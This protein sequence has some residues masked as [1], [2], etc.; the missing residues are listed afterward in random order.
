MVEDGAGIG[1]EN[2]V[3]DVGV[4]FENI[5]MDRSVD[6]FIE[7]QQQPVE[8]VPT[9]FPEWNDMC[10]GDGGRTGLALGWHVVIGGATNMGK[11]M[12]ALNLGARAI[13]EGYDVGMVS[14]E[15][16]TNQ[17]KHRMYSILSGIEGDDLG[18]ATFRVE[19]TG[20]LKA[21]IGDLYG[22]RG[23]QPFFLVNKEP[24][25]NVDDILANLEWFR[26]EFGVKVFIV[27]YLQL[28]LSGYEEDVRKQVAQVSGKLF[29][30]AHHKGALTIALSQ[31]NRFTT[32]DKKQPPQA[33]SLTESSSLE[34]D[35]D[36]VALL[37]HSNY[38]VDAEK[39]WLH[40]TWIRVGKNRH[41]SKGNVP[42]EWNWKTFRCRQA[43]PDEES[44]WPGAKQNGKQ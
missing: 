37:D 20:E 30:Y 22:K 31:L 41:G 42:I 23:Q 28:C 26:E 32:R 33:E 8:A 34:N 35:A 15:M 19:R 13:Q 38:E 40:R 17:I 6:R 1:V 43:D 25:R 24:V 2:G 39:A 10:R 14:L 12:L 29:T 9:P 21:V 27:D 44:T 5:L 4:E 16:S 7:Q 18:R 11:T 36:M 3:G